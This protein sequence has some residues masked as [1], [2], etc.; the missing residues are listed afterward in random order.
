MNRLK[1]LRRK[2]GMVMRQLAVLSRVDASTLS[3]IE[4]YDYLPGSA[5]RLRIAKV[6]GLQ[7][8][9]IW[10]EL[11]SGVRQPKEKPA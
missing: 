4:R 1:E 8:E 9:D 6:L 2:N 7:V 5:I 10:P 3:T 11:E